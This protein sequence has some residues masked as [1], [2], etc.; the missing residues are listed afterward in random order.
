MKVV[1][2]IG[3]EMTVMDIRPEHLKQ[4]KRRG[5]VESP[6]NFRKEETERRTTEDIPLKNKGG[7]PKKEIHGKN[8]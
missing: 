4:F 5:W 1:K 6:D 8:D 2:S 3:G 7:R